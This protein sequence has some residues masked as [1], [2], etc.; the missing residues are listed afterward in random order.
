LI[1]AILKEL[2]VFKGKI[3]VNGVISYASQ[4][5][6]IFAGT[7]QQNILFGSPMDQ[8]RFKQVNTHGLTLYTNYN[9]LIFKI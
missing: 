2:P 7:I 1:Q 3:S 4:E 9:N 6:W 5:P 8:E